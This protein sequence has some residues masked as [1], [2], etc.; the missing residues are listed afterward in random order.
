MK[1]E[2]S[3][4]LVVRDNCSNSTISVDLSVD[5]TFIYTDNPKK[6]VVGKILPLNSMGVG[7]LMRHLDTSAIIKSDFIF[8]DSNLVHELDFLKLY[9]IHIEKKKTKPQ[10]VM[11]LILVPGNH[12]KYIIKDEVEL[13]GFYPTSHNIP[14]P[15]QIQNFTIK[16]N[17]EY[18][19]GMICSPDVPLLFSENFDYQTMDDFIKGILESELIDKQFEVAF[20]TEFCVQQ[21]SLLKS[22]E[23]S[24]HARFQEAKSLRELMCSNIQN[25]SISKSAK[26]NWN[27]EII[28]SKIG[29][30]CE[31]IDS[32]LRNTSVAEGAIIRNSVLVDSSVSNF[33]RVENSLIEKSTVE[34]PVS[35]E[36]LSGSVISES[37]LSVD[38]ELDIFKSANFKS[39]QNNA[40]FKNTQDDIQEIKDTINRVLLEAHSLDVVKIELKTLRMSLNASFEKMRSGIIGSI[41]P[42]CFTTTKENLNLLCL[43]KD[44]THSLLDEFHVIYIIL[45]EMEKNEIPSSLFRAILELMWEEDVLNNSLFEWLELK[46]SKIDEYTRK[47]I[48]LTDTNAYYKAAF[49]ILK[50]WEKEESSSDSSDSSSQSSSG[51]SSE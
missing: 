6:V 43:L 27:S 23:I 4:T 2:T 11:T 45:S 26:I 47:V 49:N 14:L 35:N 9:D 17:C 12:G 5:E 48:D 38:R 33:V 1:Q 44:F 29:D 50:E 15:S 24:K 41:S 3:K 42:K 20:A 18:V 34:A 19:M 32:I 22:K 13:V 10:L 8:L 21:D 37:I 25:S 7:D 40:T 28:D 30:G 39:Q 31:I 46:P 51:S 16:A 36:K